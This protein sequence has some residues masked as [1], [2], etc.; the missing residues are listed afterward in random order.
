MSH[1]PAASRDEKKETEKV[2]KL[3]FLQ[4]LKPL[5]VK[6]NM[7]MAVYDTYPPQLQ[8]LFPFVQIWSLLALKKIKWQWHNVSKHWTTKQ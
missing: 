1:Q 5:K 3:Q 2:K 7:K 4:R 6:P 8:Q